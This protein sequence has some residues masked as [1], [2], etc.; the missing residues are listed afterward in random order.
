MAFFADKPII[1][2]GNKRLI[3]YC[4]NRFTNWYYPITYYA[5]RICFAVGAEYITY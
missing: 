5:D 4:F 1:Q 3:T 2:I